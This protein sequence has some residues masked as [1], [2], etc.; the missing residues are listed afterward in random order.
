MTV[1]PRPTPVVK[2]PQQSAP[3]SE[4]AP[5]KILLSPVVV[6]AS[7]GEWELE[8]G[9]LV[10]G[11]DPSAQIMLED[12]LVSRFHARITVGEGGRV[13]LE[14][15]Q[16]ANGIFV[17]GVK[18]A[19]P[20]VELGEGDRL[21]IGTTEV[22]VFGLRVS[23]MVRLS[24]EVA[25][26]V[27][28]SLAQPKLPELGLPLVQPNASSFAQRPEHHQESRRGPRQGPRRPAVTG[29]TD[30]S[31]LVRQFA[32]QLMD[33]GNPLE[34]V[35]VLSEHLQNL[36]K[37]ASAGLSVP[38]VILESAAR[39]ALRL[40]QW[41]GRVAWIEYVFELHLASLCV[42]SADCLAELE[43][44]LATNPVEP[45]LVGYFVKTLERRADPISSE[46]AQRLKRVEQFTSARPVPPAHSGARDGLR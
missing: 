9:E 22:S 5:R 8:Q 3:V 23:A 21:L 27:P 44:V 18:L 45:S 13:A 36:V 35:R 37:G 33:S 12:P 38:E 17:N 31:Q 46:E 30:A 7:G 42:P 14:D 40:H 4:R 24:K 6:V 28:P 10:I 29:R 34:A 39:S 19:R 1:T 16:S 41:T 11:R 43:P 32:E 2:A 15:L 25:R 26:I 20:R